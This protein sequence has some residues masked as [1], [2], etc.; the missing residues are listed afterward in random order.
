MLRLLLVLLIVLAGLIAVVRRGRARHLARLRAEWGRPVVRTHRMD[1]IAASYRSRIAGLDAA[2]F[3]DDRTWDD[4][5]LDDVFAVLDR[6]ESTLGQ[7]A[8]YYRLRTAPAA[9]HLDAFEA[10]VTRLAED[11]RRAGTRAT[12]ALAAARCARL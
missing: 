11:P 4:L 8:L 10:L 12:G 3:L 5:N 9:A 7:H 6:T 2:D 1:A